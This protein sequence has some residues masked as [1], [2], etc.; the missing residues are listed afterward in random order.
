MSDDVL[1]RFESEEVDYGWSNETKV[2]L[3][4][5]FADKALLSE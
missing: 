1:S 4:Q 3:D 5:L 2:Q